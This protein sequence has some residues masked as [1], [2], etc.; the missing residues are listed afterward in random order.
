MLDGLPAVIRHGQVTVIGAHSPG[1]VAEV[2]EREL[3]AAGVP[4]LPCPEGVRV[5]R[6]GGRVLVQNW[7]DQPL[8]WQGRELA[9]V[10][11]EVVEDAATGADHPVR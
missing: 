4:L 9:P 11:F 1:L 7:T 6:R 2:L 8:S 5:S 3:M 10:G